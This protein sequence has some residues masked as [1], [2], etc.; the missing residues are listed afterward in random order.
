MLEL[1]VIIP[2]GKVTTIPVY[3]VAA[4]LSSRERVKGVKTTT[5]DDVSSTS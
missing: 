1:A 3:V 2:R 5:S 4:N